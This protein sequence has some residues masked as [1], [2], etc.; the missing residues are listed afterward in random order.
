MLAARAVHELW[1]RDRQR[2]GWPSPL[3]MPRLAEL[4]LALPKGDALLRARQTAGLWRSGWVEYLGVQAARDDWGGAGKTRLWRYQRHYH[5]ELPALAALAEVE[6]DGPWLILARG[7]VASWAQASPPELGDGW[8][9]YP[10]AR[11]LLAWAEA[12]ALCPALGPTLAPFLPAQLRHL[13]AHLEEHLRGNHLIC[14]AA[15]LVAGASLL[16][17]GSAT[18]QV[19]GTRPLEGHARAGANLLARELTRQVLIDGTYAE[20]TPRYHALV[21]RDALLARA[22]A[23]QRGQ[24]LGI[25]GPL[26]RLAEALARL[27]RPDGTWPCLNDSAPD[28]APSCEDALTLAR[29]EGLLAEGESPPG[30]ENEDESQNHP[31]PRQGDGVLH[32]AS[33]GLTRVRADA[34]ELLFLHAPLSPAE[35]P[36]HA[37]SHALSFELVWDGRPLVTDSG[38]T[39]YEEG[40][41]RDFERSARAHSTVT[42]DGEGP[43]ELW[44]AFRAGGR[45]EVTAQ[46]PQRLEHGAFLLR[47]SVRAF[48]GF[49]HERA[50]IFWPGVTLAVLDR[51]RGAGGGEVIS[52]LPLDPAFRASEGTPSG[53]H[54]AAVVS[55]DLSLSLVVLRGELADIVRGDSAPR[56]GFVSG[57]FG[58]PIPRSVVRMRADSA[59]SCAYA[60]LA[61]KATADLSDSQLTLASGGRVLA[62]PLA[63][64]L[65]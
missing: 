20:R 18:G 61:A 40:P 57:G 6:P 12:L 8:E 35:Q 14:D 58:R 51:V 36:G 56:D 33:T 5:D 41:V 2:R 25:D 30:I 16:H 42:V 3:P 17:E 38:V 65:P 15:A 29:A 4:R 24:R 59:G 45:G 55:G 11:R 43:D 1:M 10:V 22:L 44:A 53:L 13:R 54:A 52:R 23:A 7:L 50:L 34:H 64:A 19:Q 48:Q 62:V 9:P 26:A 49:R 39:T 37:H 28:A 47:G 60:L 31:V 32:L 46:E 63:L 21:L 27:R